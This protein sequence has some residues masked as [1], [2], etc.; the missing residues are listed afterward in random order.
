[1][2]VKKR[3][4]TFKKSSSKSKKLMKSKK[5]KK[6][7]KSRKSRKSMKGGVLTQKQ[8]NNAIA[9]ASANPNVKITNINK[10]REIN[11]MM[12]YYS[13]NSINYEESRLAA[14]KIRQN[15][16]RNNRKKE[17]EKRKANIVARVS[18]NVYYNKEPEL[19]SSEISNRFN[20]AYTNK[21]KEPIYSQHMKRN[22]KTPTIYEELP[23]FYQELSNGLPPELPPKLSHSYQEL[24]PTLPQTQYTDFDNNG[25]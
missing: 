5:S 6:N 7:M 10:D 4:K 22:I 11:K 23:H 1:M 19:T 21:N 12:K 16:I 24:P 2:A 25:S 17:N 18:G 13:N 3:V 8:Y 14:M 9:K 20:Q 15:K